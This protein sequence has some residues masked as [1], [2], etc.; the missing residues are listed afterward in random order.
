MYVFDLPTKKRITVKD[1]SFKDQSVSIRPRRDGTRARKTRV[2]WEGSRQG[3]GQ[4]GGG[5]RRRPGGP[6]SGEVAQRHA[7][8]VYFTRLSRDM[9][10]LDTVWP[11]RS[12]E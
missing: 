3:V 7:D 2:L 12:R 11:M 5:A 6:R 1:G 8:K 9:K 10:K 4:G